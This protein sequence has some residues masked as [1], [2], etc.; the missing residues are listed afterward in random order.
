MDVYSQFG[1]IKTANK[2]A[3]VGASEFGMSS[4]RQGKL[5]TGRPTTG[6]KGAGFQSTRASNKLGPDKVEEDAFTKHEN[7]IK[8]LIDEL[9]ISPDLKKVKKC[10]EILQ[11]AD[12]IKRVSSKLYNSVMFQYALQHEYVGDYSQSIS[13]YQEMIHNKF[14][15][16]PDVYL[17][18]IAKNYYKLQDYTKAIKYYQMAHDKLENVDYKI[19]CMKS[20]ANI[21]MQLSQDSAITVYNNVLSLRFDVSSA[22]NLMICY[23]KSNK[24]ESIKAGFNEYIL[25]ESTSLSLFNNK[26]GK[27]DELSDLETTF[28][29]KFEKLILLCVKMICKL[30][31][32]ME[33]VQTL[34]YCIERVKNSPHYELTH[35]LELLKCFELLL[36]KKS[37]EAIDL[38]KSFELKELRL[39]T[40]ASN[41]LAFLY[42]VQKDLINAEKYCSIVL[43][44]DMYNSKALVNMGC[45]YYEKSNFNK[46]IEYFTKALSSDSLCISALHNLAL[47]KTTLQ[48]HEGLHLFLKL[49]SLHKHHHE[50]MYNI[51]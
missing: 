23:Y 21:Y 1:R 32:P 33:L 47:I 42:L 15:P 26:N 13:V 9:Y 31:P 4:R 41:N 19:N 29:N 27:S 25:I 28:T 14:G 20:I 36:L 12:K 34:D 7:Q 39:R 46:A 5:T 37:S 48:Q 50:A 38:Y 11:E 44:Q 24:V 35:S 30:N 18:N 43:Q 10:Y 8:V 16:N 22:T 49:Y 51:L 17:V 2:Q 45:I 6:L 40:A 3:N